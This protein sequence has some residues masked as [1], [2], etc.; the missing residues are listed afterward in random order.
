MKYKKL[1]K[2]IFSFTFSSL[3]G[4]LINLIVLYLFT[5]FLNLYYLL[6][7][8]IAFMVSHLYSF[9]FNDKVTFKK[10]GPSFSRWIKFFLVNVLALIVNIALLY[11]FTEFLHIYYLL[12]QIIASALTFFINFILNKYWAFKS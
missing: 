11:S 4:F 9:N 7:A 6:S 12:S 3:T 8:I 5:E 1:I 2:Q 10:K